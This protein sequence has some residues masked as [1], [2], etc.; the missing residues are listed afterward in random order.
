MIGRRVDGVRLGSNVR[1]VAGDVRTGLEREVRTHNLVTTSGRNFLR[2]RVRGTEPV[3]ITHIGYGDD[4]TA[5][6]AGQTDLLGSV[7][8]WTLSNS[9]PGTGTLTYMH[10]LPSG[11]G[12]LGT[13]CEIGLFNA[14]SSGTM[15]ARAVFTGISKTS[16][17]YIKVVWELGWVDD[18]V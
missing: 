5:P 15:Y 14:A 6:A 4:S 8:R 13:L 18:G 7:G 1:V 3:H 12:A 11:A 10:Y 16:S 17:S 9:T 2:D